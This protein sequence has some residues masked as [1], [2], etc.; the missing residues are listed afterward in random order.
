M[1]QRRT[2][3]C[4][5]GYKLAVCVADEGCPASAP[6][7]RLEVIAR[8]QMELRDIAVRGPLLLAPCVLQALNAVAIARR[9]SE[10]F[11]L[12]ASSEVI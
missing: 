3:A 4:D 2:K 5:D 9:D 6:R 10:L 7:Q 8:N 11:D 1:E 12:L